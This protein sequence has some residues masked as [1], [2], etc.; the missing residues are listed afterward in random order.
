MKIWQFIIINYDKVWHNKLKLKERYIHILNTVLLTDRNIH[1]VVRSHANGE[2][3]GPTLSR[4][5]PCSNTLKFLLD[6]NIEFAELF[7]QFGE[8]NKVIMQWLHAKQTVKRKELFSRGAFFVFFFFFTKAVMP[9]LVSLCPV[10]TSTTAISTSIA[11]N[12]ATK[13]LGFCNLEEQQYSVWPLNTYLRQCTCSR[14]YHGGACTLQTVFVCTKSL[15]IKALVTRKVWKKSSSQYVLE[16]C[17]A[18]YTII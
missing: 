1:L 5:A 9:S 7:I 14:H 2:H 17:F 11:R 6:S 8:W 10:S 3:S 18:H 13:G 4:I 15:K 12:S 16:W